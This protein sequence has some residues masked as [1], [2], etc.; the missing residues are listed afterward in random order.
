MTHEELGR[1]ESPGPSVIMVVVM[2]KMDVGRPPLGS[3]ATNELRRGAMTEAGEEYMADSYDVIVV[4]AGVA[5]LSA[6]IHLGWHDRRRL[7]STAIRVPCFSRW[8]RFTTSRVCQ[9]FEASTF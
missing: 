7:S 9:R 5:G 8:R 6:A 4:G 1:K 3:E 2:G